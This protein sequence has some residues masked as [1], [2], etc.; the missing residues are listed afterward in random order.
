MSEYVINGIKIND[1]TLINF[2]PNKKRPGFNAHSRYEIY[3]Y[4]NKISELKEMNP[5]YFKADLKYDL[6]HKFCELEE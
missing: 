1:D 6:L 2:G 4:A 3:Q 5:V